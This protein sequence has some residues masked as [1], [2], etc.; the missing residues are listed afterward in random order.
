MKRTLALI[1]ALALLLWT[2]LGILAWSNVAERLTLVSSDSERATEKEQEARLAA[3]SDELQALHQDVRA[4]AQA[5]GEN[6]QALNDAWVELQDERA[7]A[8]QKQVAALRDEVGSLTV[9]SPSPSESELADLLREMVALRDALRASASSTPAAQLALPSSPVAEP[10]SGADTGLAAREADSLAAPLLE[11]AESPPI[12]ADPGPAEKAPSSEPAAEGEAPRTKR[13]FLAFKLPSDD[14]RFDERRGWTILPALSRVGFDAKTTLHDFTATTSTLEGELEADFSRPD[15]APRASVR[16]RAA[17]LAS[18]DTDRDEAM[19]EHLAVGE[20]PSLDFE[21]TAFEPSAI[22]VAGRSA[23]GRAL[24]RMTVRGVT[25]DVAMPVR[26]TLDE[27]RRLCVEG[28]MSLDL[29]SYQVPVPNKLGLIS[30]EKDVKV[31]ISLRLRADPRAG[32]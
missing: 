3:L 5:M 10:S 13:S 20:H 25:R 16:V 19:R 28:E 11:G 4:L 30:M 21:L 29:T 12:V 26:I 9:S 14:L 23:T 22:D 7:A 6:L 8:L 17:T 18:G 24:G 32:G 1:G 2:G 31:W 15:L 27:A